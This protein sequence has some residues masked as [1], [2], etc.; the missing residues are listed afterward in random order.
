[1]VSYIL[2][3]AIDGKPIGMHV[4]RRHKHRH[5]YGFV[6]KIL[7]FVNF[8]ACHNLSVDAR[9]HGIVA[10]ALEMAAWTAEKVDHQQ[11]HNGGDYNER[12]RNP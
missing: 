6:V 3:L 12:Y 1:M 11:K 4:Q 2:H 5:L 10:V 8:L 7:V 9:H